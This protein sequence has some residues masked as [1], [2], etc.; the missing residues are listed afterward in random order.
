[1]DTIPTLPENFCLY[2]SV[3]EA[4]RKYM[5]SHRFA[6]QVASHFKTFE[7]TRRNNGGSEEQSIEFLR[8]IFDEND[9][10][11]AYS[12]EKYDYSEIEYIILQT[13]VPIRNSFKIVK[14]DIT[15]N[16]QWEG[17][18]KV[19]LDWLEENK[20]YEFSDYYDIL[21]ENWYKEIKS[22]FE[23]YESKGIKCRILCWH[24]EYVKH[25]LNDEWMAERFIPMIDND[26]EYTCI[27]NLTKSNKNLIINEDYEFFGS[28][29]PKDSHPSMK[30]HKIIANSIIKKIE[31]EI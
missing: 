28:N 10:N 12:I 2:E 21:V 18:T 29:P 19:L 14:N 13:S 23:F 8:V 20:V 3:R 11:L 31:N 16:L 30:C 27:E 25:I 5:Y 9:V 6:R 4:H 15:Y 17:K 22:T 24:E 7:I 1:M 26:I